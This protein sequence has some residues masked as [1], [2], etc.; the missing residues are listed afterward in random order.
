MIDED[1]VLKLAKTLKK[2]EYGDY[3]NGTNLNDD[4]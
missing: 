2:T 4:Y 3:L 1:K